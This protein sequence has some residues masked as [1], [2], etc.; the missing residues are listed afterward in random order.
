MDGPARVIIPDAGKATL[1]QVAI[2]ESVMRI[3]FSVWAVLGAGLACGAGFGDGGPRSLLLT[4]HD[5]PR[6]LGLADE[7]IVLSKGRVALRAAVGETS[8]EEISRALAGEG[9]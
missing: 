3:L 9:A 4:E 5:V 8:E 7:V 2:E 6:A 1:P